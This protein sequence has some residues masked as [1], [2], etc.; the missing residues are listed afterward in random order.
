M[1]CEQSFDRQGAIAWLENNVSEHR[2]NHILGVEAMAVEL[3]IIH[4]VNPQKAKIAGLLHDLAKFFPPPKL[5]AIAQDAALEV[6]EICQRVPHLIHA[7][8]SAVVAQREFGITDPEIL[9]A[10]ALHT[11]GQA[12]MSD[13]DCIIFVADALE[14]GRGDD[15]KLKKMREISQKNLYKAVW[16]VCDYTLKHLIKGDRLIHPRVID[17]RNWAMQKTRSKPS[18]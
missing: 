6:D 12:N 16:H 3:A 13:L 1:G 4:G 18:H 14:P 15:K 8:V 2:L 10:I 7:D 5:L 11:L 9:A 17:T